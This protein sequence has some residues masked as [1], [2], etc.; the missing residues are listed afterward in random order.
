MHIVVASNNLFRRE[1]SAYILTEA[2]HTVH[3]V[4]DSS[5]LLRCLE[6]LQPA[7]VLLDYWLTGGQWRDMAN[8]IHQR[9]PANIVPLLNDASLLGQ[10]SPA[11]ELEQHPIIWPFRAE[12]LLDRVATVKHSFSNNHHGPALRKR[13]S[14]EMA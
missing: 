9:C 2:G 7:L 6:V 1:L 4:S 3:E 11:G 10:A 5:A 14:T 12:D 13:T 8:A